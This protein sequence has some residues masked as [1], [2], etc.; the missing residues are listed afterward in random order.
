MLQKMSLLEQNKATRSPLM[1]EIKTVVPFSNA[2]EGLGFGKKY[3][4]CRLP[5]AD[6]IIFIGQEGKS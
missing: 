3:L 6:M 1:G 4:N 5:S 2:W